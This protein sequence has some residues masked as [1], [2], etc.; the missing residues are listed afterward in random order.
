MVSLVFSL[1]KM[2]RS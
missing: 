1:L 2:F